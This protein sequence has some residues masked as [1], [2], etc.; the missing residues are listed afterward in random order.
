[1]S[2]IKVLWENKVR[3]NITD[4]GRWLLDHSL[5]LNKQQQWLSDDTKE[6]INSWYFV[7]FK[8]DILWTCTLKTF[9]RLDRSL[10]VWTFIDL[11]WHWLRW[12]TEP[13]SRTKEGLQ[14]FFKKLLLPLVK[15]FL[16]H[17]T[18]R[19]HCEST[20]DQ[21]FVVHSFITS[22]LPDKTSDRSLEK[23]FLR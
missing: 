10:F 11:L 19:W 9:L 4:L 3:S 16:L 1:M 5:W 12:S 13:H 14:H 7:P 2:L 23:V 17:T 6:N 18:T 22:V 20:R 8:N 21:Q 15:G